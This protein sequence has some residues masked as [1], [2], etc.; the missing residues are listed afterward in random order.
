MR[1]DL[2]MTWRDQAVTVV[3]CMQRAE[4]AQFLCGRSSLSPDLAV[5]YPYSAPVKY[6][7]N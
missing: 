6:N 5:T 1:V 7:V 2:S 4:A 3:R